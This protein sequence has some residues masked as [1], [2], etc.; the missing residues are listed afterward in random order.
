[1]P[2][3][4]VRGLLA[5]L[6]LTCA[7]VALALNAIRSAA[8]P[9]WAESPGDIAALLTGWRVAAAT[10]VLGLGVWVGGVG[11]EAVW[12]ARAARV[13][14]VLMVMAS[15]WIAMGVTDAFWASRSL[16]ELWRVDGR[17]T[18]APAGMWRGLLHGACGYG[19][20]VE[21]RIGADGRGHGRAVPIYL[22]AYGATAV[23]TLSPLDGPL[24]TPIRA[25]VHN[26]EVTIASASDTLG[27][28]ALGLP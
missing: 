26:G 17:Q 28:V 11:I 27:T 7:V 8:P 1:M 5:T 18:S 14:A 15:P 4:S 12:S 22:I 10:L 19:H 16:G 25:T 24:A 21:V 3:R 23:A 20:I 6:L 13:A 9:R 2:I